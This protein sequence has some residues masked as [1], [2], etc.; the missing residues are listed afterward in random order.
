MVA[1]VRGT[2]KTI[3]RNVEPHVL[4]NRIRRGTTLSRHL[5]SQIEALDL[6]RLE[7]VLSEAVAFGELGRP[8]RNRRPGGGVARA[9]L[10]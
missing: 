8:P 2:A 3:R 9:W 1:F 10:D 4:A 6:P 5:L 7:T